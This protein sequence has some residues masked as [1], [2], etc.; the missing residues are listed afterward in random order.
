VNALYRDRGTDQA[1]RFVG[2]KAA[3]KRE[4]R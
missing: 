2:A 1:K 3:M 4:P